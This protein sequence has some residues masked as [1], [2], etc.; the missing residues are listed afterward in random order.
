MDCVSQH[1]VRI[2]DAS[3]ICF[4]VVNYETSKSCNNIKFLGSCPVNILAVL[5]SGSINE[6]ICTVKSTAHVPVLRLRMLIFFAVICDEA[7][8]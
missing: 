2:L 3:L 1:Y 5:F 8:E 4:S 6:G 7:Q